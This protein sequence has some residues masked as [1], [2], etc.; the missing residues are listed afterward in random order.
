LTREELT[1]VVDAVCGRRR[2][3]GSTPGAATRG[4]HPDTNCLGLASSEFE[5][6]VTELERRCRVPLLREALRCSTPGE[7]VALVN[8]QVTSGV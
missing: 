1:D 3:S 6:V 4:A 8:Q 2:G 5:D 7:L